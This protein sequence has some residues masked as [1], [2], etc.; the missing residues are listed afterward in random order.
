MW[1]CDQTPRHKMPR[2]RQ[3]WTVYPEHVTCTVTWEDVDPHMQ[4]AFVR[5]YLLGIRLASSGCTLPKWVDKVY[6]IISL[7]LWETDD[8]NQ[9]AKVAERAVERLAELKEVIAFWSDFMAWWRG[10]P[11]KAMLHRVARALGHDMEELVSDYTL[12][13]PI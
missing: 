5:Q 4:K 6:G 7:T 3:N 2:T 13:M 9:D 1:W 8:I 12:P 10:E 11:K